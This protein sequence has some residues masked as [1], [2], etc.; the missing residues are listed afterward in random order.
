M[1]DG[2]LGDMRKIFSTTTFQPIV[3]WKGQS[4]KVVVVDTSQWWPAF[5]PERISTDDLFLVFANNAPKGNQSDLIVDSC[6]TIE[7]VSSNIVSVLVLNQ[8]IS[9][10][11]RKKLPISSKLSVGTG[12]TSS[13]SYDTKY[14]SIKAIKGE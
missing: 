2:V 9:P 3:M 10:P 5:Q 8:I 14:F 13:M 11:V 12:K 6:A 1:S 7:Y 4:R